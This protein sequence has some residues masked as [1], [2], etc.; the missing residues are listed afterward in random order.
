MLVSKILQVNCHTVFQDEIELS[1]EIADYGVEVMKVKIIEKD[2]EGDDDAVTT[3]VHL[4]RTRA[5]KIAD[6]LLEFALEEN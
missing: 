3:M 2:Y 1:R 5:K 4:D 6:A